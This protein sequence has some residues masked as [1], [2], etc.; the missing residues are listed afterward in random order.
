[1]FFC[2][3]PINKK[4]HNESFLI[5][6]LRYNLHTVSN[7]LEEHFFMIQSLCFR[8]FPKAKT[9]VGICLVQEKRCQ[10]PSRIDLYSHQQSIRVLI[11]FHP[12]QQVC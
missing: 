7:H 1:M 6:L 10:M 9:R 3:T 12:G 8:V 5:A 4:T 11:S 2:L